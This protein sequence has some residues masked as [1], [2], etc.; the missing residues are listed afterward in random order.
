[1]YKIPLIKEVSL[2]QKC[3]FDL[4]VDLG[5]EIDILVTMTDLLLK[6]G[7]VCLLL[8]NSF[9]YFCGREGRF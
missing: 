8:F 2:N 3:R 7:F 6:K 5:L 4:K 1:M 9:W